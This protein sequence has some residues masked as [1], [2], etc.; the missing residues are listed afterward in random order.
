MRNLGLAVIVHESFSEAELEKIRPSMIEPLD[1]PGRGPYIEPYAQ[2]RGKIITLPPIA[3]VQAALAENEKSN[4]LLL[5]NKNKL[6]SEI[7]WNEFFYKQKKA[8]NTHSA[9][10]IAEAKHLML[11]NKY[12]LIS[13]MLETDEGSESGLEFSKIV[14]IVEPKDEIMRRLQEKYEETPLILCE[15]E[16]DSIFAVFMNSKYSKYNC[17]VF[18]YSESSLVS[19]I[20][21]FIGIKPVY[22]PVF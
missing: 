2:S 21:Y 20:K 8:V 11:E 22:P 7:I 15:P 9:G 18:P 19:A 14:K 3:R 12:D 10:T 13:A 17:H 16:N 1:F 5:E 4:V 6:L